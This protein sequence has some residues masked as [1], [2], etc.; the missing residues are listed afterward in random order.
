M[1]WIVYG[2]FILKRK[3]KKKAKT[4][5]LESG[6]TVEVVHFNKNQAKTQ[7]HKEIQ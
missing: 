4:K 3:R 6:V 1:K 5:P 7:N 2:V